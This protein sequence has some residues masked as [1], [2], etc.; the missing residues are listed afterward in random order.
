MHELTVARCLVEAACSEA[1][2]HHAQSV[3]RLRCRIGALRQVDHWMLQEAFEVAAL[4]TPC[5]TGRLLIEKVDL[6]ARCPKCYVRFPINDGGWCCPSCGSD[7][8][9]FS[10]GDE[11]ELISI[12]VELDDESTVKNDE[13]STTCNTGA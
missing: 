9:D 5:E 13:A 12:D 1:R 7:G 6:T 10:G 11:L 8:D 3:R 2:R 4:G